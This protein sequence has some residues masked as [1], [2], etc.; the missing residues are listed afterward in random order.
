MGFSSTAG[1][2]LNGS[3]VANNDTRLQLT[4]GGLNQAGSVFSNIPIG[5]Q[6]FTTSFE[7]QISGDAQANGFTFCIQNIGVNALGGGASGLGYGGIPKSVAVKFNFYDFGGEGANS[8]G[9]YSNGDAPILPSTDITPSGIQLSSGDSI[10]AQLTYDGTTLT[11]K[12]LDLVSNKTFTMS[13]AI[14]IPQIVGGNT[15]YVGF[16]G[17]TGGLSSSQKLLSWTYNAQTAPTPNPSFAMSSSPITGIKAGTFLNIDHHH[18]P[19]RR[20][21]RCCLSRLLCHFKSIGAQNLPTCTVDQ[22]ASI[23]GSPGGHRYAHHQNNGT[24]YY[25]SLPVTAVLR[26]R[27]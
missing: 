23:S 11:L 6:A 8:T 20:L 5:I 3:A 1:L 18:H 16:T 14:N 4:D 9:I 10:Q 13:Q 2:T 12:L 27:W 22:S 17:G 25:S 19:Q 26:D 7:F 24:I 15:A 21:H